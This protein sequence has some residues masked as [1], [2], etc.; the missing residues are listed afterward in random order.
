MRFSKSLADAF[1]VST[2]T[3]ASIARA[4]CS[5]AAGLICPRVECRRRWPRE[6]GSP[7]AFSDEPGPADY[8][9]RWPDHDPACMGTDSEALTRRIA[10]SCA[11]W[12]HPPTGQE[13]CDALRAE[14]RRRA[15][16][17]MW[18]AEASRVDM[19][20]ARGR[21]VYS[22]RRLLAS[23]YHCGLVT[24]RIRTDGALSLPGGS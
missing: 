18:A 24:F 1:L 19:F 23:P 15:I 5:K 13:F 17:G 4:R 7:D 3:A 12:P 16:V 11:G 6:L 9:G 21:S 2:G 22:W 8:F 10:P 14:R 20:D